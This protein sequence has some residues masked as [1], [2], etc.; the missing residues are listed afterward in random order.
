MILWCNYKLYTNYLFKL[1]VSIVAD[2]KLGQEV[3]YI[4]N[5]TLIQNL[6]FGLKMISII[7]NYN[8]I[9]HIR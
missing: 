4:T 8:L 2:I 9:L 3:L 7:T 1:Y 6:S 5:A